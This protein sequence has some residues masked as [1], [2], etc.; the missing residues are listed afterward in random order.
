MAVIASI[1]ITWAVTGVFLTE[2]SGDARAAYKINNAKI[3]ECEKTLPRAKTCILVAQ[4]E[5]LIK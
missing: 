4:P 3:A 2:R 1:F 5:D